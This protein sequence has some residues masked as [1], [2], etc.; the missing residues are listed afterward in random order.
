MH[1]KH[2][3]DIY[4]HFEVNMLL[5]C[6]VVV[7]SDVISFSFHNLHLQPHIHYSNCNLGSTPA[8]Y[9]QT[10]RYGGYNPPAYSTTIAMRLHS[11]VQVNYIF[12]TW[13][14]H[15]NAKG[16]LLHSIEMNTHLSGPTVW[17]SPA[18]KVNLG[19]VARCTVWK[20]NKVRNY[21]IVAICMCVFTLRCLHYLVA[22]EE[23]VPV[24]V[25]R[26]EIVRACTHAHYNT[27]IYPAYGI[28]RQIY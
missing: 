3:F 12:V 24:S 21:L 2:W 5:C 7:S 22:E 10:H 26:V 9:P 27:T 14:I 15:N 20:R 25:Q 8:S 16:G 23:S 19:K 13:S 18:G 1:Y 6:C 4:S 17:N 11:S 28:S